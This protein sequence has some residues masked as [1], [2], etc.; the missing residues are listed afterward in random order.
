MF[1]LEGETM[2]EIQKMVLKELLE[3]GRRVKPRGS[4]VKEIT[5]FGFR[6]SN[7]RARLIYS[8][9]RKMNLMFA[10]GELLWYLRGTNLSEII[11]FYNKRY[12]NYSD[13][14]RTLHG[15][16][17]VRLFTDTFTGFVQWDKTLE[18]LKKDPDTRQAVINIHMPQDLD[19][20]SKDIPC[21]CYL[22]FLIRD[23][24]LECIV[25]MRSNDI[26][27]GTCYDVFSFTMMQEIMA[28]QLGIEVGPYSHFAGSM[29][30]Y[31]KHLELAEKI[32]SET[33]Y[34]VMEMLP[35]PTDPWRYIRILLQI[36]QDLRESGDT[37]VLI[38]SEYW[39]EL[40]K[41]L[42]AHSAWR[43]GNQQLFSAIC[44]NLLNQF[45]NLMPVSKEY[46]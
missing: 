25:N 43:Q 2:D 38:G 31:D 36:E 27:W 12:P 3:N 26:I 23:N 11:S 33:Y 5:A 18:L 20:T 6:L 30:I 28:R 42:Y 10:V 46:V 1:F 4:W 21:T 19:A 13:D 32:I 17:G 16:Y 8:P 29:H 34:P 44:K 37:E 22:Q 15:A 14:G 9:A 39:N 41:V 35:M 7:P 45:A 24:K 40:A